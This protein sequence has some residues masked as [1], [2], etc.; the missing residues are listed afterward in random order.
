MEES[1]PTKHLET[2]YIT[3]LK[4]AEDALWLKSLVFDESITAISVASIDGVIVEVNAAFLLMWGYPGKDEVISKPLVHFLNNPNDVITILAALKKSGNWSG[5]YEAKRK[6]GSIFTAYGLASDLKDKNGRI[7]GYQSSVIEVTERKKAD[8]I[9]FTKNRMLTSINKY[10]QAIAFAPTTELFTT[11]ATMLKDISGAAEV[12]INVYDQEKAELVL[13]KSTLSEENNT[14]IKKKFGNKL[15]DVRTPVPKAKYDEILNS[16]LGRVGSIHEATFGAIPKSVG[17]IVEKVFGFGWFVGLALKHNERLVGT[18]MIA[19]KKGSPEL[20]KEELL[21]YASVTASVLAQKH[22]ETEL[23]QSENRLHST[24]EQAAVGIAL[25]DINGYFLQVNQKLCSI[26]G[27]TRE[28]LLQLNFKEITYPGDLETDLGL[29]HNVL[30]GQ[31]KNYTLEKRYIRKDSSLVWINLTVAL[32]RKPS[33]DPDYAIAVVE[34]ITERKTMEEALKKSQSLISA[35]V[36]S[37]TDMIWSVDS[38]NFGLLTFNHGLSNHFLKSREI[39]I[40]VGMRPEDLY[41]T[42]EFIN[43]WH[44]L[45]KQALSKGA[46]T[47]EYI[48]I[49]GDVVLQLTFNILKQEG[50]VFAISAFGRDITAQKQAE[51]I[52]LESEE[53]YRTL[54]EKVN[55]AILIVQD[56]IFV[57][58]N[59]KTYE[60]TGAPDEGFIGKSF[61]DFVW[62]EDREMVAANYA[63]RIAGETLDSVYDFRIIGTDGSPVWVFMSVALIQYKGRPATLL[64]LTNITDRKKAEQAILDLSFHDQLTGL[65]NRRFF[66]EELNRLDTKRQLPLSFIMGDLNGLKLINDVFGHTE[67]DNLLVKTAEILK[68]VCR[69]DDILARWGGDEFVLLLPK[70]SAQDAEEIVARIKKECKK[71]ASQKIPLS[72]SLGAATKETQVQN[73]QAI[74]IDAE[75]NMYRN[76]LAQKES[77]SSSVI[78][79]LEQALYEKSNESKE[80]INRVRDLAIKLGK[81]IDLHSNQLDELSLL[82]SLHDIGKV[83]ISETILAKEGKLTKKEWDVIKRHPEIGFNIASSSPQIAHIAK[84]ILAC[85]ENFDGSGYPLGIAGESIPIISRII[86]ISDTYDVMTR[87]RIYKEAMSKD[88]EIK[89]LKKCAGSQFDPV[90]VEKFIEIISAS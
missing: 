42:E 27:Y 61:I 32:T 40:Q 15:V 33:W 76:K 31:I 72:L 35:I 68:K 88:D 34:D 12:F 82:A 26:V 55:E 74:I 52:L 30:D 75:S 19:G 37:T 2:R 56:G 45:Y 79:A 22:T 29:M 90:L 13:R 85:H 6:D 17:R 59:S 20:E 7:I 47:T 16:P 78:F 38:K 66:E 23:F 46:Y 44:S 60:I 54:V 53:K 81:S 9:L 11:I 84:A 64:M 24:F 21:A 43:K 28:E 1:D 41:S 36:N 77:I 65:Y 8:E 67:G 51:E 86:L 73:I 69:S 70:T 4:S 58:A 39:S 49:V 25:V 5:E 80:H 71:T 18:I 83:A 62:P 89:E 50:K 87:G 14:W 48:G 10:I 3:E 57:F 63:K